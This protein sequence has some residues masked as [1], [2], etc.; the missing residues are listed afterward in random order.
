MLKRFNPQ[1]V[2]KLPFNNELTDFEIQT[3]IQSDKILIPLNT[4]FLGIKEKLF[5]QTPKQ[6]S[7]VEKIIQGI[8]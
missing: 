2:S 6:Q 1:V 8:K 3:K 5:P 4:I 7:A